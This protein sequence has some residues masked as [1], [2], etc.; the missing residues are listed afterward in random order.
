MISS[1]HPVRVGLDQ[2]VLLQEGINNSQAPCRDEK[3]L[4]LIYERIK[5]VEMLQM[6]LSY[7][8]FNH[9]DVTVKGIAESN[10]VVG[11]CFSRAQLQGNLLEFFIQKRLN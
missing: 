2:P 1:S 8:N 3:L 4:K 9:T 5:G 10:A 7:I 11:V 6:C